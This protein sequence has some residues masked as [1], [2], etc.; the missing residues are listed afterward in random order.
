MKPYIKPDLITRA[1]EVTDII[2]V[3]DASDLKD[4]TIKNSTAW[5]GDDWD[6]YYER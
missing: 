6:I 1:F 3:S 4:A 5:Q 2:T